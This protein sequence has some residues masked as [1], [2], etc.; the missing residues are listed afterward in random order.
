[1]S[2]LNGA[3]LALHKV[4]FSFADV[5]LMSDITKPIFVFIFELSDALAWGKCESNFGTFDTD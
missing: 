2:M 3:G 1:M 4:Q 5:I